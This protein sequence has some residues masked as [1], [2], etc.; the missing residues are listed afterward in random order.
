MR[1]KPIMK[2]YLST[3]VRYLVI[4]FSVIFGVSVIGAILSAVFLTNF[5]F[6]GSIS[7]STPDGSTQVWTTSI[8]PF[9][10]FTIILAM[11]L[12]QKD[13]RFLIT[14]SV[15]RKEIFITNALYLIPNAATMAL[16]QIIIIYAQAGINSLIVGNDF[17]GLASDIQYFQAANMSNPI[18]FFLVSMTIYLGI[19]AIC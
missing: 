15:S 16:M 19:G 13:T 4:F 10:I 11:I 17:N 5:S 8:L 3:T 18:I 7:L 14:R 2:F 12:S 9:A 6:T 1:I